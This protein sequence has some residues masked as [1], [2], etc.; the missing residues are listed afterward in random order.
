MLVLQYATNRYTNNNNSLTQ[1]ITNAVN[2]VSE[3]F[4]STVKKCL[5]FKYV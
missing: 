4:L 5:T 2:E 1:A 3:I